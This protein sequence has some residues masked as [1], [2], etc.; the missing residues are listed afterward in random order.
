M[1]ENIHTPAKEKQQA[2][3]EWTGQV[4]GEGGRNTPKDPCPPNPSFL[5]H[6]YL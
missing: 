2:K 1:I 5:A 6:K 4:R 3:V